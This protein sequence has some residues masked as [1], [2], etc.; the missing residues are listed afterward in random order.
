M[1]G[2]VA[3][4]ILKGGDFP[5][6]FIPC[7]FEEKVMQTTQELFDKLAPLNLVTRMC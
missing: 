2:L 5:Q 7:F 6:Q 1:A 3:V 4:N